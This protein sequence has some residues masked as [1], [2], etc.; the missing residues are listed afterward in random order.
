MLVTCGVI[1]VF[2]VGDMVILV[3][4]EVRSPCC[5]ICEARKNIQGTKQ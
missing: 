3:M 2:M 4:D 1:V 5:Y